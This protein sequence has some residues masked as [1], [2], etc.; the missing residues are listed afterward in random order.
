MQEAEAQDR[1][2]AERKAQKASQ[3]LLAEEEQQHAQAAAK[4]AKKHRQKAKKQQEK[5]NKQSQE[6]HELACQQ[7][8]PQQQKAQHQLPQQQHM[9]PDTAAAEHLAVS[10][11][12]RG[13][14]CCTITKVRTGIFVHCIDPCIPDMTSHIQ[15]TICGQWALLSNLCSICK[16]LHCSLV[17]TSSMH[18][19]LQMLMN[20]PVIAAD[21]YT[22]ERAA[23]QKW[24]QHSI[25]SPVIGKRME[26]SSFLPKSAIKNT[27]HSAV[28]A[29]ICVQQSLCTNTDTI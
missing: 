16:T 10:A 3:E 19:L 7:Q 24:L 11:T 20:E 2:A 14:L 22:Y 6:V 18:G 8:K 23:L 21:G 12:F 9:T 15:L 26:H 27:I 29:C 17:T 28:I 13:L 25:M 5:T 1:K 4:K